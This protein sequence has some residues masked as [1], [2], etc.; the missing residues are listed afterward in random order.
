MDSRDLILESLSL[1]YD[2]IFYSFSKWLSQLFPDLYLLESDTH[3]FRVDKFAFEGHCQ[4]TSRQDIHCQFEYHWAPYWGIYGS[5]Y[6]SWF[7]I[8]WK[9]HNFQLVSMG[10]R[11]GH[12]RE[13]RHFL[14]AD[15]REIAEQFFA[16]VCQWNSEVRG[17]V[18][19]FDEGHWSKSEELFRSIQGASFDNLILASGL[20]EEI[21][22]DVRG[23]FDAKETYQNYHIAWKRGILLLGPPGNGKTHAVKALINSL[24]YPCLYIKSFYA[25]YSSDTSNIGKVFARARESAPCIMI[26]EDL[27]SLVNSTNRSFFLNELDGF[28]ANEGILILGTT[29]HPERLDPAI[30]ERPSRF[31]RKYTFDLPSVEERVRY[32]DMFSSQLEPR[33]QLSKQGC[34][35]I[36]DATTGYSFAYLKELFLSSMM[37]WI[38]KPGVVSMDH[39]M[40]EQSSILRMQMNQEPEKVED[41]EPDPE[42]PSELMNRF[43]RSTRRPP[44]PI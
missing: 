17:E 33:L 43:M 16:A 2:A 21:Q 25:E 20:A 1:P 7:D 12:C 3:Y 29:N 38:A 28:A 22:A 5:P 6:N 23:F 24:Q 18:L 13:I 11:E 8:S 39:I 34:E 35:L 15:S 40:M 41:V 10:R 19:V 31:D 36:G 32:L 42:Y 37:K 44:G 26:L 4:L 14:L 9:Q 30:L 27:D